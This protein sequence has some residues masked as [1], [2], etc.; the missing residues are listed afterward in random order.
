MSC[1]NAKI[2][3]WDFIKNKRKEQERSG[4]IQLGQALFIAS[5]IF[6]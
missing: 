4:G 6:I 1:F 3:Q 2:F 5:F